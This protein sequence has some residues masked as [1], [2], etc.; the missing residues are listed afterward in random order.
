[1]VK[2]GKSWTEMVAVLVRELEPKLGKLV[3]K[4][5]STFSGRTEVVGRVRGVVGNVSEV[6][7]G[8]LST[9]CRTRKSTGGGIA[10]TH[11]G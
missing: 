1:M 2:T 8:I 5:R 10:L 4:F 6:D 3:L 11:L 7:D 9:G